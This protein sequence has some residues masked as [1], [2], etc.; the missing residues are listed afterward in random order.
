M[1]VDGREVDRS[2]GLQSIGRLEQMLARGAPRQTPT[3]PERPIQFVSAEGR[4]P[5]AIAIPS[6]S[7]NQGLSDTAST[8]PAKS[9]E[10]A[11]G[12]NAAVPGWRLTSPDWAA[13]SEPKGA[14]SNDLVA[15]TVR[16]RVEDPK[17]RSI[18]SGTIIDARQGEALILTCGHLFR[19][20][21]GQGRVEVDLFG[22]K[23]AG[24][25]PAT[26]IHFDIQRDL[27][28]LS[29][30]TPGPVTV[31]RV[32]P[33]GYAVVKGARAYSCGCNNGGPP[34][35]R[36]SVITSLNRYL[37]TP[38]IEAS[39][40]PVEGRSGGGLFSAEGRV[41]GV[42]NAALS[43]ENEGLYAALEAIQAELDGKRLSFAYRNDGTRPATDTTLAGAD[44]P[45]MP[46]KMPPPSRA[47]QL[48]EL[49]EQGPPLRASAEQRMSQEEQA[50]LDEIQRRKAEGAEVVCVIRSRTNPQAQSEIIVVE[51]AS[52][53]F[54]QQIA[55][56][57]T[58]ARDLGHSGESM[59]PPTGGIHWTSDRSRASA[60]SAETENPQW[61]PRWLRGDYQGQ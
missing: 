17:G 60:E 15:A 46:K 6:V 33:P 7:S 2:L 45:A 43:P 16:V 22:P 5:P 54:L 41:I 38:N 26:L 10:D 49:T 8:V 25:V 48:T 19:D 20:S 14:G 27:G 50:A 21:K 18:G 30:R 12:E 24:R 52:P 56:D 34:T 47:V 58:P 59:P 31:A 3:R 51:K 37:D 9:P 39:G 42:C 29:I 61:N 13:A 57:A 55:S 11:R 1:L 23:C 53:A 40:L 4:Q 28:L 36:Q 44:L 32:A 35:V